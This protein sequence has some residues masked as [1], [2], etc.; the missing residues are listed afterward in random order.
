MGTGPPASSPPHQPPPAR[1]P[2]PGPP[3]PPGPAAQAARPVTGQ[4]GTPSRAPQ[5]DGAIRQILADA[6]AFYTGQIAGSWAPGYLHARGITAAA[7][8]DWRIGCAP[9][10][11]N[12][13]TS[14]LRRLGHGD[15]AIQAA[16]L[17][18][19]SS[20]GTPARRSTS[21][22]PGPS[23][24]TRVTCC[25]A[26]TW[27]API[28]PGELSPSSQKAPSTPL[29]SASPTPPITPGWPLRHRTDLRASRPAQPGRR[30][31]PHRDPRR[32]RLRRR[33]PQSRHPRPRHPPPAHQQPPLSRTRRQ[34][35]R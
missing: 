29:P 1:R 22:A 33:R 17:A 14:H 3:S 32:V 4:Q 26:G 19:R 28:P 15:D 23:P 25:S 5:A 13:L 10:G 7:I 24:I 35:P 21:T 12:A 8:A 6:H 18:T 11:W 16:G 31:V 2:R 30:P 27:A 20:R 9:A 34:G